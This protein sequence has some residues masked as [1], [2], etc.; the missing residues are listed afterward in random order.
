MRPEL[1]ALLAD[2][3]LILHALLATF[4]VGG[5]LVTV[6]GG[7]CRW[8]W[9]RRWEFRVLH[10]VVVLVIV[11]ESVFGMLCPLTE[12]EERLRKLAG[13]QD[14]EE[15][16]QRGF[17]LYYIRRI[18]FLPDE[19]DWSNTVLMWMYIAFGVGVLAT[20]ILVPPRWPRWRR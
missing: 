10:L 5:W 7:L 14:T 20:W 16:R 8:Q 3:V 13:Q 2:L 4:V 9:V 19:L 6:A 15:L 17:L 18:L 1:A 11:L 12:W